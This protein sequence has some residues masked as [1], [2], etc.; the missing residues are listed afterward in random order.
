MRNLIVYSTKYGFVRKCVS[1]LKLKLNNETE[2]VDAASKQFP[3]LDNYNCVILGGSIYAGKIQNNLTKYIKK[4]LEKLLL[5]NIALFVCSGAEEVKAEPYLKS[6]FP[7]KLFNHARSKEVFGGEFI[8]EKLTAIERFVLKK[9]IGIKED[10][11]RINEDNI[12]KMADV[13]NKLK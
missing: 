11:T 3:D 13:I 8:L 2:I 9:F 10:F 7:E 12:N 1:K 6:S 4:N 5:K